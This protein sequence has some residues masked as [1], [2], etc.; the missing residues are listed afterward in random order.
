MRRNGQE[1]AAE[2]TAVRLYRKSLD[3]RWREQS[4]PSVAK[5]QASRER[6]ILREFSP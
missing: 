4:K 3:A 2:G 5:L 6:R 1:R